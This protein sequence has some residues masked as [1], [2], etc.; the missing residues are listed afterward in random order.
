MILVVSVGPQLESLAY[1]E[2]S[3]PS[4]SSQSLWHSHSHDSINPASPA[5]ART[6]PDRSAHRCHFHH[7]REDAI[8]SHPGNFALLFL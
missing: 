1:L 6:C 7:I 4:N 2:A 3:I 5:T 8:P